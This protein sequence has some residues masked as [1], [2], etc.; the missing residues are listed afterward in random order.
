MFKD[1]LELIPTEGSPRPAIDASVSLAMS[2]SA[3]LDAIATGYASTNVPFLADG[4]AAIASSLQFGCER[5]LERAEAAL[6]VFEVEAK[7]ARIN[8]GKY[9]RSGTVA[10]AVAKA[11]AA[12]RLYDLTIVSQGD[13]EGDTFDNRLPKELLLQ[14][15]G[16][17]L[18]I[19]YTFRGAFKA[20]RVGICWDG[21]RPAARAL[22]DAM[23]FITD[24]DALTTITL[25]ASEV[26]PDASSERLLAHLAR[27]GLPAKTVSLQSE[28]RDLQA[29]ILS[30]AADESL[31][32]LI[33][34]GYGHSRLQET[35]FGGVTRAMFHSMTVPVLMSH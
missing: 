18:F 12:A 13:P 3:H 27:K 11:G 35:V 19:P 33:M 9:A 25:N 30:I 15:G 28:R 1:L 7:N 29:S 2:A 23:P 16:P 31:D 17:L 22:R 34:G 24:A 10:E 5:A 21:S 20:A 4:G 8:Y 32:L 14:A 26:P 6:R